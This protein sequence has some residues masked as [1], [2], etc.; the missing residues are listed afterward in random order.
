M[1]IISGKCSIIMDN[2]INTDQIIPT[3]YMLLQCK[4]EMATHCFEGFSKNIMK[5]AQA[6]GIIVAGENFGCGS[7]REQAAEA[8]KYAG[9]IAIIGVSISP[10]FFRNAI[11]IGLPVFVCE[12]ANRLHQGD[13]INI[14]PDKG[15]ITNTTRAH[16]YQINQPSKIIREIMSCG[17]LVNYY[18]R[19]NVVV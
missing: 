14:N 1:K 13:Y 18:G 12:M 5:D 6:G 7:A 19:K 16:E 17:G 2:D 3:Q 4:K 8:I 9:F 11:N 10:I 15:I